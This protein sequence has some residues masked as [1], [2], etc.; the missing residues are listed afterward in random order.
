MRI[1]VIQSNSEGNCY[2]LS[3]SKGEPLIIEA[4]LTPTQMG[5]VIRPRISHIVGCIV[6]HHHSDH[7]QG[8]REVI[9]HGI[10]CYM[11]LQVLSDLLQTGN[12]RLYKYYCRRVRAKNKFRVGS[13]TIYSYPADHCNGDM[14]P[15]ECL[16]YLIECDGERVLF[17]TDTASFS[18]KCN[19][20]T[21]LMVECNYLDAIAKSKIESGDL[22]LS[23]YERIKA[24]HLDVERCYSIASAIGIQGLKSIILLHASKRHGSEEEFTSYFANKGANK[25]LIAKSGLIYQDNENNA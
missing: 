22:S 20:V 11:P 25:P 7:I 17:I 3:N 12:N 4:G 16:S 9:R 2:I 14:T 21:H 5:D 1:E 10:R 8:L 13:Y 6:S 23:E 18:Y 15:C 19:G 24:S